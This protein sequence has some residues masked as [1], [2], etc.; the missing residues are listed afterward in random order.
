[1][2]SY[3]IYHREKVNGHDFDEERRVSN[4]FLLF[5]RIV[6]RQKRNIT[7]YKGFVFSYN[8]KSCYYYHYSYT[9]LYNSVL[10]LND[11]NNNNN[12][13]GKT[14]FLLIIHIHTY[15]GF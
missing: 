8:Y 10:L 11:D 15:A 1:M 6:L 3:V 4:A 5:V 12:S 14:H 2:K 13:N 9:L 7:V